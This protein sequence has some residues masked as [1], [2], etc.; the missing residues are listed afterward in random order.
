[1]VSAATRGYPVTVVYKLYIGPHVSHSVWVSTILSIGIIASS[2]V[3]YLCS[4]STFI[5][6]GIN[7]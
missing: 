3:G 4:V 6:V 5:T 1:M 7:D 2:D